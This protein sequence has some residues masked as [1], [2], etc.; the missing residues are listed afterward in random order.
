[1]VSMPV[2]CLYNSYIIKGRIIRDDGIS[3][4]HSLNIRHPKNIAGNF[5]QKITYIKN[6]SPASLAMQLVMEIKQTKAPRLLVHQASAVPPFSSH[7]GRQRS[8]NVG[9][10]A[11]V[12][13]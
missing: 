8:T 10:H 12:R 13:K 1:M 5:V 4:L 7:L 9:A 3:V 6:A 2:A 11:H